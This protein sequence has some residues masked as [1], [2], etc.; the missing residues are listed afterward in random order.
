MPEGQEQSFGSKVT[1]LVT[2]TNPF[3]ALRDSLRSNSDTKIDNPAAQPKAPVIKD[4]GTYK[5]LVDLQ[6]TGY[7]KDKKSAEFAAARNLKDVDKAPNPR[8]KMQAVTGK[9]DR[10]RQ[11]DNYRS[12]SPEH[13]ASVMSHYYDKYVAP[14]L[15]ENGIEPPEKADWI[16]G[17]GRTLEGGDPSTASRA[18]TFTSAAISG[19]ADMARLTGN[20]FKAVT[21]LGD[22]RVDS[23]GVTKKIMDFADSVQKVSTDYDSAFQSRHDVSGWLSNFAGHIIG[24]APAYMAAGVGAEGIIPS[25]AEKSA[26][27]KGFKVA[28]QSLKTSGEVMA[29]QAGEGKSLPDV[30]A[31][32]LTA[33]ILGS[34]IHATALKFKSAQLATGGEPLAN[35]VAH[36]ANVGE[37]REG[38]STPSNVKAL[39]NPHD[40][41]YK[42][43]VNNEKFLREHFAQEFHPE[44]AEGSGGKSVWRNL[45]TAQRS[46]IKDHISAITKQAAELMPLVNPEVQTQANSVE[47]TREALSNPV[48]GQR[49]AAIEKLTGLK[50]AEVL[51][52][53]QAKSVGEE[54]GLT[55]PRNILQE[56][57]GHGDMFGENPGRTKGLA[58]VSNKQVNNPMLP[59][60]A[61]LEKTTK[62]L[63]KN[64][65]TKSGHDY[66]EN[67]EHHL[68]WVA[69]HSDAPASVKQSAFM[70]LRRDYNISQA[71]AVKKGQWLAE[72]V[73]DL[74]DTGILADKGNIYR[75]T[76]NTQRRYGT[77]WQHQLYEED[78]LK[79][80]MDDLKKLTKAKPE[81]KQPIEGMLQTLNN[82]RNKAQTPLTSR[83][84]RNKQKEIIDLLG[85]YK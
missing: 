72:H 19:Q 11:S 7:S 53:V 80:D 9:L 3:V 68:L 57:F 44:K 33:F 47:M 24:D 69:N 37:I 4:G 32:G 26:L 46:K 5:S 81:L 39:V 31:G 35:K 25:L 17:Y 66:F 43:V 41:D 20:I 13:Q 71:E 34:G 8:L 45:S 52:K 51:T 62:Y 27:S 74:R 64:G 14:T 49:M 50:V 6:A 29:V 76:K 1:D 84:R 38:E 22:P 77:E 83:L 30:F 28:Y 21:K 42:Q 61:F 67:P 54:T 59:E 79:S 85:E 82:L 40:P 70:R 18:G 2:K 23:S 63:E 36:D 55:T 12:L 56:S 75:S 10:V 48:F 65:A 73:S 16:K 58:T 15:K 78:L 60:G